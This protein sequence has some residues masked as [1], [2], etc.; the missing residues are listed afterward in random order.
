M[1]LLAVFIN[2]CL[3][4]G[5]GVFLFYLWRAPKKNVF[6]NKDSNKQIITP[7]IIYKQT[8]DDEINNSQKESINF[9][10]NED[11]NDEQDKYD[12]KAF[13][14]EV[15]N[16]KT[17]T[18]NK[19]QIIT[20]FEMHFYNIIVDE[21]AKDYVILPQVP[22][23]SIINKNKKFDKQYQNELYRTIDIGIFDKETRYPLLL[24]EIN[25]KSHTK[26][27]R[28][29]RDL[30]VREIA[31]IAEIPLITFYSGYDNTKE[32]IISRVNKYLKSDF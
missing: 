2:I 25:D 31:E 9:D 26:A 15:R 11:L 12:N 22:L 13:V 5:L 27:N 16:K 30:K 23:S 1:V 20:D 8:E 18:Y 29:Q 10:D 32:Y 17:K 24:I 4:V 19:K 7:K 28:Y 3:W 14:N 21:F 6:S